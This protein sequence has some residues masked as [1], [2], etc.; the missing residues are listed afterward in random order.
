MSATETAI[1]NIGLIL[2]YILL[3][4][5]ILVTLASPVWYIIKH[6]EKAKDTLIGVG[7]I[8]GVVLLGYLISGS[9][10]SALYGKFNVDAGLSKFIGGALISMYIFGFI[11]IVTILYS[12]VRGLFK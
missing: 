3:G 7:F 2:G 5:C 8:L 12:E 10:V 4:A 9:E 6:P 11:A 1:V